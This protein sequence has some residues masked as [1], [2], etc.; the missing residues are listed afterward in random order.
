MKEFSP[1]LLLKNR[2]IQTSYST[3]FRK[4]ISL[5]FKVQKFKLNDGDFL[6]AYWHYTSS[7]TQ[8]TPL[9][10]LFHGL[11][12]SFESPYIQGIMQE[13]SNNGFNS[14]LM[15]FRGCATQ[16]NLLP[17]SYHSGETHDALEFIQ[18]LHAESPQRKLYGVGYSLGANM[19]LKLL[20]EVQEKSL[21]CRVVAVSPP[22]QL[23]I[24][25]RTMNRG[26]AKYYQYRLLKDLKKA[27]DKKY[28]KHD[29]QKLLNFKR[30]HIKKLNTFWKYDDTFT[31]PIH[32]FNSADEYYE[33]CSSKQFLKD[34]RT[35]TLIIHS[36]DD[37][38]MT[39]EVIPKQE[40][41]SNSIQLQITQRGGHVGFVGGSLL[42]P[43]YWLEKRIVEYFKEK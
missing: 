3:I 12:G 25:A 5:E 15:H 42:H 32:G 21:L 38:F 22:M 26:F 43:E 19:L 17:R 14:V 39:P 24:C 33:K 16:E 2:H 10:I 31:A 8:N 7:T 28:D 20:G 4:S 41:L 9:V 40:E 11:T 27:L 37:P 35:P 30:T 13:L 18:S 1:S 29:M 36:E 23:D 6:E 34:I